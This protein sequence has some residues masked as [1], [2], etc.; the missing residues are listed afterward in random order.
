MGFSTKPSKI[1]WNLST[2]NG[3]FSVVDGGVG[4]TARGSAVVGY[5]GMVV[6][7]YGGMVVVEYSMV[8]WLW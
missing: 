2:S 8:V 4:D 7:E 5:G 1:V 6:V 3:I